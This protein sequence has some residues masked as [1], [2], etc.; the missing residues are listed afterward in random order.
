[1]FKIFVFMSAFSGFLNLATAQVWPNEPVGSSLLTENDFSSLTTGCWYINGGSQTIV[2]DSTAPFSPNSVMQMKYG[3]GFPGGI[4]PGEEVC[5]IS[6]VDEIY[7]AYWW[8]PSNS[9]QGHG[10]NVNKM[11]FLFTESGTGQGQMITQ[12]QGQPGGPYNIIQAIEYTV[13]NSHL[14]DGY[15]DPGSTWLLFGQNP[16]TVKLGAWHRIEVYMK[17][18]KSR[19]SRDGILRW[20]VNGTAV[21]NYDKVNYPE[22]TMAREFKIDP[23]WGGTGDVKSQTDYFWY[24]HIRISTGGSTANSRPMPPKNLRV[25]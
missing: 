24:D 15:G 13:D 3:V 20:W 25:Q 4:S 9:W 23:T 6:G 8:K 10:S 14:G 1:M 5:T 18:S 19:S 16:Y 21:G 12:M 17:K 7:Y 11:S 22:I 2:S